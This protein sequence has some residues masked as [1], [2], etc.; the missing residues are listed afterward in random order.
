MF[1][2]LLTDSDSFSLQFIFI[3]DKMYSSSENRARD[4]TSLNSKLK[5]H[6]D[7]SHEFFD[8]FDLR[9]ERLKNK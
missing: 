9:N 5:D 3:C 4:L 2:L 8:N 1:H 6:L 7:V